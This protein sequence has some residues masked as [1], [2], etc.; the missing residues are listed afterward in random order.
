MIPPALVG[1]REGRG[2]GGRLEGRARR[3]ARRARRGAE[4]AEHPGTIWQYWS[5]EEKSGSRLRVAIESVMD[6]SWSPRFVQV[7]MANVTGRGNIIFGLGAVVQ[8]QAS[9]RVVIPK[10]VRE[11]PQYL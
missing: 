9:W 3:G 10:G 11:Q 5:Q 8:V 6:C 1:E 7:Y 4:T 2:G